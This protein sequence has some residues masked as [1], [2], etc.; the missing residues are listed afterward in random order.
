VHERLLVFRPVLHVRMHRACS[1]AQHGASEDPASGSRLKYR[2]T[3]T[4]NCLPTF[5]TSFREQRLAR[6]KKSC[7]SSSHLPKCRNWLTPPLG[8]SRGRLVAYHKTLR[9][10][11]SRCSL[12]AIP[13][14]F[15]L[16]RSPSSFCSL[17]F[18]RST[19]ISRVRYQET[20]IAAAKARNLQAERRGSGLLLH[21]PYLSRRTLLE[22][23][24][25]PLSQIRRS[26]RMNGSGTC[27]L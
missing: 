23:L 19:A 9:D 13:T 5:P 3:C 8:T 21:V 17:S 11:H 16:A 2:E 26:S 6:H 15:P 10:T 25:V 24:S 20:P 1:D 4:S 22:N 14:S 12:V 7:R 27:W 18:P